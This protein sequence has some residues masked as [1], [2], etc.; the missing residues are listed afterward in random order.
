MMEIPER[1]REI[2]MRRTAW[3]PQSGLECQGLSTRSGGPQLPSS[4]DGELKPLR[5]CRVSVLQY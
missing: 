1:M 3:E 5:G 4:N 2:H